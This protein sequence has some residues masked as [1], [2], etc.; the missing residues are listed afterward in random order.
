MT[1]RNL[2]ERR[3]KV[4]MIVTEIMKERDRK[5]FQTFRHLQ[6][7]VSLGTTTKAVWLVDLLAR[8]KTQERRCLLSKHYQRSMFEI[9]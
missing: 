3:N 7:E 1:G 8:K 2:I 6:V 4:V 5:S 9:S